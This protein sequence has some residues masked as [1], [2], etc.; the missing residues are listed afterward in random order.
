[1]K[2]AFLAVGIFCFLVLL[3]GANV[4]ANGEVTNGRILLGSSAA[5][6]G[7][8]AF[9]GTE[10]HKGAKLYFD[11]VN[12]EGGVYGKKINVTILDD[13]YEPERTIANTKKLIKEEKVDYLFGYIGTPTTVSILDMIEQEKIPL[14]AAFTG[15]E[16]LR[17]P[18]RRYMINLRASYYQETASLVDYLLNDCHVE[19]IA[20]FYQDDAYGRAGYTGVKLAL[21]RYGLTLCGEGTYERNTVAITQGLEKIRKSSPDAVIMIGQYIACAA[22]IEA[23][24]V[25]ELKDVYF[26]NISFVGSDKLNALLGEDAERAI[27]S[28][29]VPDLKNKENPLTKEFVTKYQKTYQED[30]PNRVAYEGYISAVVFV[31]GLKRAGENFTREGFIDAVERIKD[32]DIGVGDTIRYGKFDHQGLDKAYYS[33]VKDGRE[34]A[35]TDWIEQTAK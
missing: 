22:F 14:F 9:L 2:R 19:K 31:E 10:F 25:T 24:K 23:A 29:V 11:E 20:C 8:N 5:L 33:I 13:G 26:C 16:Q 18:V 3:L 17:K 28:Q 12:I 7:P 35:L 27:C 30:T 1:M 34:V 6:K 15:A 21:E 4:V 32:L